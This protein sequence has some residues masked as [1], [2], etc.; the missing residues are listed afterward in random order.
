MPHIHIKK[1]WEISDNLATPE[2]AYMRR[3]EF[4]KGT[5]LTTSATVGVLY[6]CVPSSP[7]N[8]FPDFKST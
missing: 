7:P 1:H 8:F 2:S 4:L 3:R 5:T 6:G